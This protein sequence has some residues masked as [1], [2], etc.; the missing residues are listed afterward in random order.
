[1]QVV[2]VVVFVVCWHLVSPSFFWRWERAALNVGWVHQIRTKASIVPSLRRQQSKDG[3][4][5]LPDHTGL[6]SK[7]SFTHNY[8]WQLEQMLEVQAMWS[9]FAPM[10]W[11]KHMAIAHQCH[12]LYI[13]TPCDPVWAGQHHRRPW[14]CMRPCMGHIAWVIASHRP[15]CASTYLRALLALYIMW[16]PIDWCHIQAQCSIESHAQTYVARSGLP[17]LRIV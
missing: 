3:K 17:A 9:W 15:M 7:N 13:D 16:R 1:M 4:M 2:N 6:T 14:C 8:M 11:W 12:T 10:E 5:T